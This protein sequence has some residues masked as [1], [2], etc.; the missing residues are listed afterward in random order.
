MADGDT[1]YASV[2]GHSIRIR[3]AQIDA[4]EKAQAFG[5]RSEQSLRELVGKRQ[6]ELAWKSLDRYGRP[7]AQVAV[8]GLDV[9]AEQVK[10]GFAWVFR[11]YS[12]DAA[13]IALEAKA[14]EAD[15]AYTEANLAI[16]NLVLPN[17]P[18]GGEDDYEVLRHV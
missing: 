7:I 6:V 18:A 3:L 13:L 2:D 15:A 4:P 1:L 10:R 11:R 12:N 16:Q 14:K 17:V 8:D 5:R 9:N